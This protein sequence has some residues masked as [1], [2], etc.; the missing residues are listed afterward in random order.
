MKA[1]EDYVKSMEESAAK[2]I[3]RIYGAKDP[4]EMEVDWDD[5]FFAA[6]KLPYDPRTGQPNPDFDWD[7]V[8]K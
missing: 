1:I 3:A 7:S 8:A 4:T 6:M 5:P 2:A